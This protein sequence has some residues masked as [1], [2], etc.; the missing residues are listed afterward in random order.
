MN[1]EQALPKQRLGRFEQVGDSQS[2]LLSRLIELLFNVGFARCF[3]FGFGWWFVAKAEARL[4]KCGRRQ[5]LFVASNDQTPGAI[6]RRD[7]L[8][9]GTLRCLVEDYQVEE[10]LGERKNLAGSVRVCKPAGAEI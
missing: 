9:N 5:L 8:F 10:L 6:N 4:E 2:L 1:V 3:L 7:S